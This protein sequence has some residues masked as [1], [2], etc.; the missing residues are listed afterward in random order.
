MHSTAS[1]GTDIT[2]CQTCTSEKCVTF[3]LILLWSKVLLQRK[4]QSTN[5][6]ME[7]PSTNSSQNGMR[8][9]IRK[10]LFQATSS[11]SSDM[12]MTSPKVT[13]EHIRLQPDP[14]SSHIFGLKTSELDIPSSLACIHYIRFIL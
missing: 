3:M 8:L 1:V 10:T 9:M 12:Y 2:Q 4:H 5:F 11:D 7:F 6:M 13:L 14:H